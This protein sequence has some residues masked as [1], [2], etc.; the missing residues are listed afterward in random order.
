MIYF[1]PITIAFLF[2]GIFAGALAGLLPG[3]GNTIIMILAFP[4]FLGV[5]NPFNIIIFYVAC[6]SISQYTGSITST[7]F[8]VPGEMSSL[9]AVK[10]GHKL[11]RKG[12]GSLSLSGCALGSFFGSI[13]AVGFVL[14]VGK[15]LSQFTF[16]D[17][18]VFQSYVLMAVCL[19]MIVGKYNHWFITLILCGFGYFLA[20]IGTGALDVYDALTFGFDSLLYGLP[21]FSVVVWLFVFPQVLKYWDTRIDVDPKTDKIKSIGV[22]EHLKMFSTHWLSCVRGSVIGFF[23]GLTPYLTTVISSNVSY[24]LEK[25]LREK[26][27][28]YDDTGDYASLVSAET[29]NNAAAL[30]SL[31]PLLLIGIP[32]TSSEAVLLELTNANGFSFYVEEFYNLF[33]MVSVGLVVINVFGLAISWPFAK[34]FYVFYYVDI[35]TIY[36]AV[37]AFCIVMTLYLGYTDHVL[38]YYVAISAILAVIGYLLRKFNTMPLIF[39]FMMQ[40]GIEENVTRLLFYL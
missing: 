18:T 26:K 36:K 13:M 29:A 6:L 32:I 33:I 39:V 16:L 10:E 14:L 5:E 8:S 24:S 4:F 27:K 19:F 40:D 12:L 23:L 11:Y 2:A 17:S 31:L 20:M 34:F 3:I 22:S 37:L 15:G 1:E 30:S 7:V 38:I 9:P 25:W 21:L 28:V 35:Q